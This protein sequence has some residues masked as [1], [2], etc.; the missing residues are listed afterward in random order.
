MFWQCLGNPLLIN[1]ILP[2]L[3]RWA[4]QMSPH[5]IMSCSSQRTS[6][7]AGRV[8]VEKIVQKRRLW[9]LQGIR[10]PEKGAPREKRRKTRLPR[11]QLLD[12]LSASSWMNTVTQNSPS[13]VRHP[14]SDLYSQLH[15]I[16]RQETSKF[17]AS[18][19]NLVRSC[20][21]MKSKMGQGYS[22]MVDYFP[23]TYE[24]LRFDPQ[25]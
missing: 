16:L 14:S 5:G 6:W 10:V 15:G 7:L 12:V 23:T 25:L 3:Q 11:T 13:E 21:K 18:L 1:Y 8:V 2:S 24:T 20:L 22:I 17:K 4:K 19:G 9:S